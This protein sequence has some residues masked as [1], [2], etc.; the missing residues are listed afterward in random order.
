MLCE[1]CRGP[2]VDHTPPGYDGMNIRCSTCGNYSIA[3]SV[4]NK[5]RQLSLDERYRALQRA[6]SHGSLGSP[7]IDSSLLPGHS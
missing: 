7:L 6:K 5:L 3:G 4:L 1:I 2:A